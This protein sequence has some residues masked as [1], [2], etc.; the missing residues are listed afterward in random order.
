MKNQRS[1]PNKRRLHCK[2]C[3]SSRPY[4]YVGQHKHFKKRV[5]ASD[6]VDCPG[7][8]CARCKQWKVERGRCF[9]RLV[10]FLPRA[11]VVSPT[12]RCCFSRIPLLF[13]PDTRVFLPGCRVFLPRGLLVFLPR[14]RTLPTGCSHQPTS[15]RKMWC[16]PLSDGCNQLTNS[17]Y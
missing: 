11:L 6:L 8:H 2:R 14:L 9:S 13:L 7:E 16:A 4:S 5:P 12:G 10:L 15:R 3:T 1:K 17:Q